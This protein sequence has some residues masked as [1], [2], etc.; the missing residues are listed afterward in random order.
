MGLLLS[1]TVTVADGL[2]SSIDGSAD[3][4]LDAR[5]F[6]NGL[7]VY[8]FQPPPHHLGSYE[9]YASLASI[10]GSVPEPAD[11]ALCAAGLCALW[12]LRRRLSAMR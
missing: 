8:L 9:G 10:S 1:G 12:P 6:F 4:P 7:S 11:W 2:V 3:Y 5:L